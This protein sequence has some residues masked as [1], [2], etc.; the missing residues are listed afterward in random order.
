[1]F[2][3]SGRLSLEVGGQQYA[4]DEM[5]GGVGFTLPMRKGRSQLTMALGY[6][7]FGNK[8]LLRRDCLTFGLSV[9]SCERWFVKRKY[10]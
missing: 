8:S 1:M 10:N 2:D 7:S 6:T 5:G 9:G 4:L 3:N